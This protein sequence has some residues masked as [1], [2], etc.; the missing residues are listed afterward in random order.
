MFP[1]LRK[2][3]IISSVPLASKVQSESNPT[4]YSYAKAV[5][6]RSLQNVIKQNNIQIPNA[7]QEQQTNDIL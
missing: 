7:V 5:K 2:K 3:T 4:N 6:T 1:T